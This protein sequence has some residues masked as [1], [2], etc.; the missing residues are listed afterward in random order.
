MLIKDIETLQA[1]VDITKSID[2]DQIKS[3][4]QDAENEFIIPAIGKALYDELNEA[5]EPVSPTLDA[6]QEKL[7]PYI[8][9]PLGYLATMLWLP[10]GMVKV[11][12]S[13]IHITSTENM[14]TA[15]QWQTDKLEFKYLRSGF[16]DIDLM[17]EYLEENKDDFE[18]WTDSTAYTITREN[19]ISNAKTFSKYF[20][21][22]NS[23]RM[24]MRLKP[25]MIKV[26]DFII[27]ANLGDEYFNEI[28]DEILEDDVSDDNKVILEYI[29]KATAPLTIARALDEGLLD[30]GP[31]GVFI[32]IFN[33]GTKSKQQ[34][35]EIRIAKASE[36][37][38]IDGNN[39]LRQMRTF[40][41][42]N[43]DGE[44][45]TTYRDS[46]AYQDPES[47]PTYN[48]TETKKHFLAR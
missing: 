33:D 39:Y 45:Y 48:N 9:K 41:N 11:T 20:N 23:R 31:D 1:I 36:R 35:A 28:K 5:Y 4:I 46:D 3:S 19:F 26:E 37:A 34:P 32:N 21:I 7:L 2:F 24:F 47:E 44:T 13:G 40:L 30:V 43:A 10:E 29:Q 18:S 27:K 38:F 12:G 16:R 17:L 15:W 22:D 14:K 42:K 6:N 25:M 8:Q